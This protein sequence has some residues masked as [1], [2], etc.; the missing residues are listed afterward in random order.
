MDHREDQADIQIDNILLAGGCALIPG[1][2]SFIET[3]LGI[4]TE[5]ADFTQLEAVALSSDINE[6]ELKAC[7]PGLL[8]A[9]GLAMRDRT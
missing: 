3:K 6:A 9:L 2:A 7:A 1:V 5:I 4:P 8:I